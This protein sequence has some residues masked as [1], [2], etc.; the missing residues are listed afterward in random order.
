MQ[1][2]QARV[3]ITGAAGGIG[4]AIADELMARGAQVLLV[5]R[6]ARALRAIS[7]T[8]GDSAGRFDTHVADL[9]APSERA[10]LCELAATWRG[11]IN[12]LINNAGL[13]HFGLFEE[14]SAQ[15]IEL[16]LAVNVHAPM[17]LCHAL[18]PHLRRQSRAC[19]VNTG[20]VFGAIGYPGYVTYSA[21]KFAL[22]GFTEALQRELSGSGVT[23]QYIAP[24][25]TRTPINTGAVE[26]M[27]RELGVAMDPPG[28]VA[29]AVADLLES[30]R[31]RAV[32]GWPEKLFVR[33][34]ALL[35]GLVDRA[36][37][38]QLPVIQR[39]ARRVPQIDDGSVHA[40]PASA[41]GAD[42]PQG[43]PPSEPIPTTSL[44]PPARR[45]AT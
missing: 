28:K 45:H 33:V 42:A 11:G 34:N 24:R 23:V 21:T 35:P 27:N 32:V 1:L 44:T 5:D 36:L 30:D 15:Q 29:R 14:Q 9:T 16:A 4:C 8:H 13:N 7:L 19:I 26:Q 43:R 2:S 12:V 41:A 25:A 17:H 39:H 31:P 38:K 10:Q 6:D 40:G 18:L 22:R 37:R 20:S 3:L